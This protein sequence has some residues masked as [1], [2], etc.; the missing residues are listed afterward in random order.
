M[1]EVQARALSLQYELG[2]P[3]AGF[4]VDTGAA[5]AAGQAL[6]GVLGEFEP[7]IRLVAECEVDLATGQR[8]RDIVRY[9]IQGDYMDPGRLILIRHAVELLV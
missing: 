1:A 2:L 7:P 8:S 6:L 9:A 4:V 3:L 5:G